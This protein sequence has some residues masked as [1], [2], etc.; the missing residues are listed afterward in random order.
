MEDRREP[1]PELHTPDAPEFEVTMPVST[2]SSRL[3]PEVGSLGVLLVDDSATSLLQL[4]HAIASLPQTI[5]VRTASNG[6][7][8]ISHLQI[9]AADL[10]ITDLDMPHGDGFS[11]LSFIK[12]SG[13]NI[14]VIVAT[15][16]APNDYHAR[17]DPYGSVTV[18]AKP[19]EPTALH[20]EVAS[21]LDEASAGRLKGVTLAG[22][23]QLVE[24]ERKSCAIRVRA[25]DFMGRLHF[26][27]GELV[28]AY[29]FDDG[30]EG[31]PAAKRLLAVENADL[32]IERSYHN[33]RR[34]IDRSLKELLLEVAA[35]HDLELDK[36]RTT[37]HGLSI[38]PEGPD[39]AS[40]TGMETTARSEL[41]PDGLLQHAVG[42]LL[43]K[44]EALSDAASL[45][46]TEAT[47]LQER[48]ARQQEAERRRADEAQDMR[49]VIVEI[50]RAIERTFTL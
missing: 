18:L 30:V 48:L 28:N 49:A 15:G 24:M 25:H 37:S 13:R 36:V 41:H 16:M 43:L 12:R 46:T 8:A 29:T 31:E 9:E 19:V 27:S 42:R 20:R 4:Q 38:E 6:Q 14:P 40:G 5:R 26:R 23:L 2:I 34:L 45:L 35:E 17:L 21:L 33:H 10:V 3:A 1:S 7:E 22:F 47:A 32:E 39:V 50:L 44:A 11:L